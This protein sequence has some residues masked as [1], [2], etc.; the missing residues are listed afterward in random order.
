MRCLLCNAPAAIVATGYPGYRDPA[1][2]EIAGC[3]SCELSFAVPTRS[4]DGLY[5]LIYTQGA[6]IPGYDRYAYYASSVERVRDPLAFLASQEENYWAVRRECATL[7]KGAE[8][9]DVGTG[10]GYLTC[11]LASAGFHATGIDRS[12]QAIA[13]ASRRFG[14]HYVVADFFEWALRYPQRYDAVAMLELI[15]H[16]D[17]PRRWIE[18]GLRLIKPGGRLLLSTPN[19]SFYPSGT[20]WETEA[21]PVHL[22]WFSPRAIEVLAE[23]MGITLEFTDFGDCAI[24]PRAAP[25]DPVHTA[26]SPMLDKHGKPVSGKRRWLQ[27]FGLLEPALSIYRMQERRSRAK[28][29][30]RADSSRRETLVAVLRKAS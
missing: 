17:D 8:I 21:P 22:W 13:R 3:F 19:R 14:D 1:R 24:P 16:V 25:S 11:A 27:R 28:M 29:N 9:L 5:E 20:V 15:E 18:A 2:Y 10:L 26:H 30:G 4:D 23:G 7:P 6:M 12:E